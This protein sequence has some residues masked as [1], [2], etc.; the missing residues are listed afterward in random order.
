MSARITCERQNNAFHKTSCSFLV[1]WTKIFILWRVVKNCVTI[2][3]RMCCS[4]LR[5]VN[6]FYST[7]C[8]L[9]AHT[10]YV[11]HEHVWWWWWWYHHNLLT[12]R[13]IHIGIFEA[14]DW[15]PWWVDSSRASWL[16]IQEFALILQRDL[17]LAVKSA[18]RPDYNLRLINIVFLL[19]FRTTRK[20]RGNLPKHDEDIFTFHIRIRGTQSVTRAVLNLHNSAL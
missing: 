17:V 5:Q 9:L 3:G 13:T 14:W 2:S 11:T 6:T 1:V 8:T 16:H 10:V 7:M 19:W 18:E 15:D 20:P 4:D 12:K